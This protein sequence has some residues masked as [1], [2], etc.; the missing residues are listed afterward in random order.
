MNPKNLCTNWNMETQGRNM[1]NDEAQELGEL[2][3]WTQ[4]SYQL[5]YKLKHNDCHR[6]EPRELRNKTLEAPQSEYELKHK[7]KFEHD[8]V[9]EFQEPECKT[10]HP[11]QL[12]YKLKHEL[13]YSDNKVSKH[14]KPTIRTLCHTKQPEPDTDE[15][16]KLVY[17]LNGGLRDG[18]QQPPQLKHKLREPKHRHTHT[19]I[20]TT[21]PT[22]LAYLKDECKGTYNTY[23]EEFGMDT[24][25]YKP[26]ELGDPHPGQTDITGATVVIAT[27]NTSL[28]RHLGTSSTMVHLTSQHSSK[29]LEHETPT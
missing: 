8:E 26:W 25:I 12:E 20:Y 18:T 23:N 5:E 15:Q 1:R 7:L 6:Q 16:L 11:H 13:K 14:G 22:S 9:Y 17:S 27:P 10:Q 4:E 21:L 19:K 3:Y 28:S 24:N 2:N 29:S